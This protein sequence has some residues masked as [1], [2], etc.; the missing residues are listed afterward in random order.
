MAG[1]AHR[2]SLRL[3]NTFATAAGRWTCWSNRATP[4]SPE[5]A[6]PALATPRASFRHEACCARA[7]AEGLENAAAGSNATRGASTIRFYC[8]CEL[9]LSTRASIIMR[10]AGRLMGVGLRGFII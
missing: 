10:K 1:F 6:Q 8:Q 2:H 3:L 7:P 4:S 5:A 9:L